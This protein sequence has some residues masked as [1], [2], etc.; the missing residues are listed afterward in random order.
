MPRTAPRRYGGPGGGRDAARSGAGAF[1]SG[2]RGWRP[3]SPGPGAAAGW[4]LV[5]A[6]ALLTQ[7]GCRG[8]HGNGH[9]DPASLEVARY[10]VTEA[11]SRGQTFL[12]AEIVNPTGLPIAGATLTATLQGPGGEALGSQTRTVPRLKAGE[13]CV[14]SFAITAR[15][16]H[17]DVSFSFG[18]PGDNAPGPVSPATNAIPQGPS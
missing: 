12:M 16:K 6:L 17:K 7:P 8:R 1:P 4:L 2:S 10:R 18:P 5:A 13:R 3:S 14:I 15:G 11:E 9:A